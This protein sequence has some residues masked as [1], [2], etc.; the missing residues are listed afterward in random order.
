M[1]Q[2]FKGLKGTTEK[3]EI[4]QKNGNSGF[5][6]LLVIFQKIIGLKKTLFSVFP[7][8]SDFSVVIK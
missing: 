3:T 1:N 7:L 2:G 8:F 4:I 6:E 5:A